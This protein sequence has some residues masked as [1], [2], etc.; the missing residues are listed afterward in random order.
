MLLVFFSYLHE[1]GGA[2]HARTDIACLRKRVVEV[3]GCKCPTTCIKHLSYL[4]L[5]FPLKFVGYD[6]LKQV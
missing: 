4:A 1:H 2:V 5:Q 3:V 6:D